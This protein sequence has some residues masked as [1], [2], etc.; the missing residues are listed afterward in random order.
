[1]E[2]SNDSIE[3][4]QSVTENNFMMTDLTNIDHSTIENHVIE[5]SNDSIESNAV[6]LELDV[7]SNSIDILDKCISPIQSVTENNFMMTDL[8]NIDHSTIENHVI[9][10]SNDS[11]ESDLTI[12]FKGRR[13][14]DMSH[15]F[16]QIQNS[17]QHTPGLG[18][19]FMDVD[20][21]S[22]STKGFECSW[23]FQ[24][25]MCNMKTVI[26]SEKRDPEIIPINKAV[27]NGTIAIGIGFTQLAELTASIDIPCMTAKIYLKYNTIVGAD[28]KSSAWDEMRLAGMEEKRLAL[29]LGDIDEDGTPMCPV[30]A[31][32]QWS[33]RSYKTKYDALSGAATIIGYRTKKILFVG[34][35]NRYCVI[36]ERAKVL[37]KSP[38]THECFLNW[39][40]GA[41]SIE[42]DAIIE[43]FLSSISIHGLK[44]NKLIGDGDSSVTKKLNEVMPYGPMLLV[45]KIECRNHIL[46]NYGQ[47]LMGLT[48]KTDYPCYLRKFISRNILRFRTA[49]TKAINH[50]KNLDDT[51]Q[52]KIEGLRN[53]ILNG[54]YHIFGH[55]L[56][57]ESYF[58]SGPKLNE[59]DLVSEINKCGL[60][61]DVKFVLRRVAD[62]SKSLILD[63]DNNYCEQLNSI[64][65]KHIAGKRIN[66]TQKQSYNIRIQAAIVSFN[67]KGNFIRTMHKK[68]T[69]KSPGSIAKKFLK[70][71]SDKRRNLKMRR[72]LFKSSGK[73][74]K[75]KS[76]QGPDEFYGLAEPL[77]D[78]L[79]DT[80][81]K[82]KKEDFILSLTMTETARHILERE[83]MQ[84]ANSQRWF[85]ERRNRLTAS[86]FGRICKMRPQTSCKSTV[87]DI[88][89]SSPTSSSL[90][91][92]KQ[93]EETALKCLEF[94]ISSKV[95]KCGLFID[96]FIPYL[97]ATPDG[98]I[99]SNSIT[100]IKC[101]YS[102]KDSDTLEQA[103]QEK[104]LP[105]IS[106]KNG[107][108]QLRKD[109]HYYFQIQGQMHIT[110]RHKC[111]FF[112]YTPEWTHL[113]IIH[114]DDVFWSK[115][116]E[117][118]LKL[119]YEECLLREIIDPQYYKRLM[120]SDIY[121]PAHIK[122]NIDNHKKMKINKLGNK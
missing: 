79:P 23:K 109:H 57:C 65:N 107:V 74:F 90:N 16:Y 60:M 80:V 44:Y 106:E 49:V 95:Q 33:K 34:I 26:T 59:N 116:M 43:G 46:R 121:E 52:E 20:F 42:A 108:Y 67:S 81:I 73:Y 118:K 66:F 22:E 78:I 62:N 10:T 71:T 115:T 103:L 75:K 7:P 86:N 24:C 88:L 120:K 45:E 27:V 3:S 64:I 38:N 63:V 11:I 41:T 48:K 70:Y 91:Y 25:R 58:C 29:E 113:E 89:Y 98:L 102:V 122:E 55:H 50:R 13:I 31:D 37:D 8:T 54:P 5:T 110:E 53:D 18:C 30:I 111:Y 1:M 117:K 15:V 39:S 93:T 92:G 99:G 32:G 114:Y 94:K 96:K 2:T 40:K 12:H 47:K 104:K 77:L 85:V 6:I 19:S 56:K 69:N 76:S 61:N 100:E 97:A 9:E 82:K 28:I 35:R 17:K 68:I 84:Q 14:V 101:P 36:C 21:I 119:F 87:Y 112:I 51:M 4:I 83:T 72:S 105:Y